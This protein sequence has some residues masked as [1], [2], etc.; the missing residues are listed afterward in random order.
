MSGHRLAAVRVLHVV[1][2]DLWAGAEAQLAALVAEL[3]RDPQLQLHAVV[4][5]S[6]ELERRL[7]AAGIGVT[8]LDE[9]RLSA[10]GILRGIRAVVRDFRPDVIH[11]HREKENVLG[12][13]AARLA[14]CASLRTVHG[15]SEHRPPAWR[16]DKQAIR[17][18]D[19]YAERHWQQASVAVSDELGLRLS[20]ERPATAIEV[21]HNGIDP[22][23]LADL[24]ER[25]RAR[26]AAQRPKRVAFLGRLVPVKRVDLFLEM[27]RQCQAVG[28]GEPTFDV[29]GE[30]PL[31]AELRGL[32]DRLGLQARV[33]FHGFRPDAVALLADV[34]A[35]VFTSD[36]EGTPMAAL[37]AIAIGVPV[38][39]RAVGGLPE[40]LTGVDG[41]R[42]VEG[43]DPA[44]LAEAVLAVLE[45]LQEPRL[46]ERYD[47]R[48]GA[49]LYRQLYDRVGARVPGGR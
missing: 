37:E 15:A 36:H 33:T 28:G 30:G 7:R 3:A 5:N 4:L 22:D 25:R 43:D 19:R 11:T 41:C 45:G 13:L 12:G 2:G 44:A 17:W 10:W 26:D 46:P 1:S 34:D 38:V 14:G 35:L 18:L 6:G 32:A 21:I 40:L 47:I 9:S 27:A 23:A 29:V 39:A 20:A 16:L 24:R 8:V 31:A 49:T 42:L 48:R